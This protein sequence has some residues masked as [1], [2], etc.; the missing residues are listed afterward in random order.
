MPS[1][2]AVWLNA[3]RARLK[4]VLSDRQPESFNSLMTLS[5]SALSVTMATCFQFFA[6]E[7]TIVGPPM[8]MFSIA[9][10]SVQPG[11]AMVAAKG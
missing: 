3:L 6:A 11:L 8:S 9:S 2:C 1:Y 4:R 10:S 5:K 7:R